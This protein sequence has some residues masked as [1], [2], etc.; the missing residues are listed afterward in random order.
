MPKKR[1]TKIDPK[2]KLSPYLDHQAGQSKNHQRDKVS[3]SLSK[4]HSERRSALIKRLGLIIVVSFVVLLGLGYYISPLASINSIRVEGADDLPPKE[5]VRA[6]GI[7]ASDKILDYLINHEEVS[8]QLTSKYTEVNNVNLQVKHFNQLIL[9]INEHKTVGYIKINNRYRKILTHGK[10][11][12]RLL[13][14]NKVNHDRPVFVGYNHEI[15]LKHDLQLFNSLPSDFQD[16]VKLLSG[17]TRRKSQV[18]FLMKDGNVVI[19][20]ISTFKAKIKLYN[21]IKPLVKKNSLIDLEVGALSRPLTASE[22]KTYGL[23]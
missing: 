14:W 17:N 11:G 7:K 15:S 13:P 12:T 23:S 1:V 6:S 4:L 19:G 2:E 9:Q 21:K 20:D 10:L 16:Q 22:K 18:I 5:V 3:D 8:R